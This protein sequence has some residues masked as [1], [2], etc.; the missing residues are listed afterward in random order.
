MN[1]YMMDAILVLVLLIP[2]GIGFLEGGFKLL[3][4]IAAFG[5][6]I[7]LAFILCRPV[8]EAIAGS[9]FGESI[10]A[11]LSSY[12]QQ[13]ISIKVGEGF[14]SYTIHGSDSVPR[15][16][17]EN[18]DFRALLY[19][20]INI[21][22]SFR[23]SIDTLL[24]DAVAS[25]QGDEIM[26]AEPIAVALAK[27][28]ILGMSFVGIAGIVITVAMVSAFVV[29]MI[30]N[31]I[32]KK[33]MKLLNRLLGLAAGVV[34]GLASWWLFG[35]AINAGLLF[36]SSLKD[37]LSALVGMGDPNVSSLAK[38]ICST[39]FGYQALLQNIVDALANA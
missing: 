36:D 27:V 6:G 1:A 33:P 24:V 26:I 20:N 39:D 38:W 17:F 12:F 4:K 15:N 3:A 21:P 35:L 11:S 5:L 19:E 30:R 7:G 32:L 14:L 2:M 8:T 18:T 22:A 16:F 31:V 28:L 9:P 25:I 23:A 34:I 37:T 10:H 29:T 13:Q